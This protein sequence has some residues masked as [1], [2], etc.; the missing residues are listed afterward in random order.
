MIR[1]A[2]AAL[3][4][5]S[6]LAGYVAFSGTPREG[7]PSEKPAAEGVHVLPEDTGDAS[8]G[9]CAPDRNG[10]AQARSRGEA[11]ALADALDTVTP[12][13]RLGPEGDAEAAAPSRASAP[14]PTASGS[15][16]ARDAY[17]TLGAADLD[18]D[19]VLDV[20]EH[21]PDGLER[22]DYS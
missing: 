10:A 20:L 7:A 11:C 21:A 14:R 1:F 9:P 19:A 17:L 22:L 3:L 12:P 5:G 13:S 18:V 2:P 16:T 6:F 4:V 15:P 8:N